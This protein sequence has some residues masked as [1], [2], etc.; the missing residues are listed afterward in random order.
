MGAPVA[1]IALR[2]I[3]KRFGQS[4]AVKAFDLTIADGEFVVLLGPTGAGKTTTLRLIAGLEQPDAGRVLI[5]GEDVTALPPA[6]RDVAFVFQQYSLYPHLSVFENLAFPLRSPARRIPPAEITRRVEATAKLV[7]IDHKLANRAAQLSGGEMQRVAIGRAL[8]RQPS[9]YLMDEPLSSLDA[10]LRA[11]MRLELKRIQ[12]ELGATLL[13]VTHDQIEAMTMADRIGILNSGALVQIGT[14]REIYTTPC[15]TY[16]AARLGHPS[17]NLL[18][19]GLFPDAD[20]P[21][22]A[23]TI[24]ARTEHLNIER[25]AN[26][27]ADGEVDWIEHLGDQDHLHVRAGERKLITLAPPDTPLAAGD[28]VMI[29]YNNPL[30]F[31]ASGNRLGGGV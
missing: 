13:Y 8:V 18:P 25:S 21:A 20:L 6:A 31:D 9:I 28:K 3:S 22:G 16:V 29:R 1:E 30:S 5:A 2:S 24:G 10:K 23:V 26:S 15:N 4:E 19:R 11:D 7:R 12:R 17:I 14:P 27:H